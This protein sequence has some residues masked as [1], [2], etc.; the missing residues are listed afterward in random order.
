MNRRVLLLMLVPPLVVGPAVVAWAAETHSGTVIAIDLDRHTLSLQEMG[1][2]KGPG[3]EPMNRSITL[4]PDTTVALVA[5]SATA[6]PSGW[7]GGYVESPSSPD[8][9]R[10]GD[11]ATVTVAHRDHRTVATSIDVVRP[12]Q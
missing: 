10:A 4:T 5:R 7:P 6:P 9:L 1:P 11:F 3:T 8:A 12:V 2:W